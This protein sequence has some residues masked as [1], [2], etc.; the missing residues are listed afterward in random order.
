MTNK[1]NQNEGNSIQKISEQYS[2]ITVIR[3]LI[4]AIPY[5]GGS[6]DTLLSD[7]GQKFKMQRI[8]SLI[9]DI[10]VRLS[11]LRIDPVLVSIEQKEEM[12]D[13]LLFSFEECARTRSE[14][15]RKNFSRIIT[16]QIIRPIDWDKAE[17]ILRLLALL[18]ETHINI[19]KQAIETPI[20][21]APFDN[22]RV[23]C[24]E[25][26]SKMK[27]IGISPSSL[28]IENPNIDSQI[29][30]FHCSELISM[31]LLRDEGIGRLG[32]TQLTYFVAT[33]MAIILFDQIANHE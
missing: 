2:D 33:P 22:L 32:T 21:E 7:S 26:S 5:V 28:I 16:N 10:N 13:M 17:T 6:L 30:K 14:L 11:D 27:H 15:K 12:Y 3:A 31:G 20:C 19:L 29:L 24:L 8:E 4:Q 18:N 1:K 25:E 9:A 23:V